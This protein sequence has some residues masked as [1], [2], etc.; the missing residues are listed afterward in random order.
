MA[1]K[2]YPFHASLKNILK[3]VDA[4]LVGMRLIRKLMFMLDTSQSEVELLLGMAAQ[5]DPVSFED[6]CDI[7]DHVSKDRVKRLI[8]SCLKNS[9]IDR[10]DHGSKAG[11][12]YALRPSITRAIVFVDRVSLN[13]KNKE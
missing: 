5:I 3:T 1:R 4:P 6:I 10:V 9:L 8:Q 12:F 11:D 13:P 2:A 7:I